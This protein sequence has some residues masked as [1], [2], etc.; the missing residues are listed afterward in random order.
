MTID[1]SLTNDTPDL[2]II[3]L[4]ADSFEPIRR[5]VR[6]FKAQTVPD[7]L[8]LLIVCPD[9]KSLGM[10]KEEVDGFHSVH[11]ISFGNLETT[12]QARAE[13]IRVAQAPVVV[14]AE[15]HAYPEPDYA[16]ALIEAH[17]GPWAGVGPVLINA[18]PG[19]I[20]WIALLAGYGRWTD[21]IPG[22]VMNDIPG[23]NSSWKRPLLL[24]YGSKLEFML[25]APTFLNWDLQARGYQLYIEPRAR[26]RHL[27]VSK[28]WLW[29]KEHFNVARL[30]PAQRAANWPWYKRLFYIA[31][32]PVLMTRTLRG[33]LEHFRRVDPSGR[34]LTT[35]WPLLIVFTMI[36][37]AGEIAGYSIGIGRAQEDTLIFDTN[38][39]AC[40]NRRD[41]Q[42]LAAS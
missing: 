39:A 40:V 11:V 7:R 9:E 18:N 25:P 35:A 6:A 24:D 30:F 8:E 37:A 34:I 28:F 3:L 21:P 27:Q 42:L 13:A 26:V 33:W 29:V 19:I 31:G 15:D 1:N 12:S 17:R 20:S 2:S 23:H 36:W 14:F 16:E 22:G 10:P 41:R 32:M 38:R 4:T 5:T